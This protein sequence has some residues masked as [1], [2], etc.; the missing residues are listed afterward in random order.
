MMQAWQQYQSQPNTV[1][2][3]LRVWHDAYSPQLDN[4]RDIFV[5]LPLTYAST[6]RRYPVI[7]MHDA[8]NLFDRYTS[9]SGEWEVDETMTA[10]SAE[11]MD[12]IIVALSNTKEERGREYCPY[13]FV[14]F[15]GMNIAGKGDAYVRF[16][17][18]TVK[19]VIDTTFR[20]RPE[21]AATGIAGSSMGGLIS[22]YAA[23]A[24]PE[25]FGMCGAFSTAYWFGDNA[26]LKTAREKHAC[27]GRVY[28]DVGTRE[29]ETIEAWLGLESEA[30]HHAYVQGVRDLR[31][32]L[33]AGGGVPGKNLMY[34]EEEGAMHREAAWAARFPAAMRFLLKAT[35]VEE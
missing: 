6:D 26:L 20:T 31:D 7:Y 4:R 21:V 34:V 13:P 1:V 28:L 9:Y 8:Q 33:I 5:W 19:P 10:L 15:G 29:G 11:G 18:E 25:V 27:P 22:L 14:S 12:A 17:S 32:A 24:Y 30:A 2:G 23:L 35:V 16:I 3:D